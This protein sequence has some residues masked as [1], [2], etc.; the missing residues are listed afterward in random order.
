MD[1]LTTFPHMNDE[2]LRALKKAIDGGFR[3]FTREY[4]E[5][6]ETCSSRYAGF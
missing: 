6:I 3:D 2:A 1:W 5:L 4:G